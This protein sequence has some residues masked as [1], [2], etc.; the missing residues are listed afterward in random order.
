VTEAPRLARDAFLA[1]ARELVADA[2][3]ELAAL[4]ELRRRAA[5]DPDRVHALFRHTHTLKGLAATVGAAEITRLAHALEDLLDALRFERLAHDV[6]ALDGVARALSHLDVLLENARADRPDDPAATARVIASLARAEAPARPEVTLD[7]AVVGHLTEYEEHRLVQALADGARAWRLS[8]R[9]PL[10]GLDR[11]LEG[12]RALARPHGEVITITPGGLDPGGATLLLRALMVSRVD[13]PALRAAVAVDGRTLEA[14][15]V[16]LTEAP[17]ASRASSMTSD[18]SRAVERSLGVEARARRRLE[19]IGRAFERAAREAVDLAHRLGRTLRIET[20]G[21]EMPVDPRVIEAL[22]AP[23]LHL[24]SNAIDHGL[25]APA[26]R[27]AAGKPVAGTLRLDAR[28]LADRLVVAVEDDGRGVDLAAIR[29]QAVARGIVTDDLAGSLDAASA[30]D[31]LFRPGF[32]TRDDATETSGRGVGLDVVRATLARLGGSV[33]LAS[34]PGASTRVT[35]TLP[36]SLDLVAVLEV[37][38]A[39]RRYLIA[40]STVAEARRLLAADIRYVDGRAVIVIGGDPVPL[41]RLDRL[42][43]HEGGAAGDGFALVIDR[44]RRAAFAV[45]AITG[46]LD[47]ATQ[48]LDP[49]LPHPRW[50]AR[51]AQLGDHSPTPLL[52]ADAL[53]AAIDP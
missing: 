10:T 21:A 6:A 3:R 33:T 39:G 25:E 24:A 18:L 32:T 43:G 49:N 52:D 48:P 45:D 28:R 9:C 16:T 51:A 47:V 29:A 53:V 1:E 36:F 37:T 23:L 30:L 38:V 44:G 5:R 2:W 46:P 42:F 4:D 12:L 22:A 11:A 34:S 8:V 19:P 26:A 50:F 27:L 17:T 7:P 41:L 40:T 20:A 35:L 31:L 15:P 14:V 13:E